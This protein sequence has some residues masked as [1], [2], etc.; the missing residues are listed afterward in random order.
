MFSTSCAVVDGIKNTLVDC[1]NKIGLDM[2]FLIGLAVEALFVIIFLIRLAFSYEVRLIRGCNA[3]IDW[4]FRRKE[5]VTEENVR[6]FNQVVKAKSPKLLFNFWTRY[7]LFR[8]GPPSKYLSSENL[9]ERPLKTSSYSA[10]IRTLSLFTVIWALCA[11][12][13]VLVIKAMSESG[14]ITGEAV[15][16]SLLLGV[17]ITLIGYIFVGIFNARKRKLLD[18]LYNT[19]SMLGRFMDNACVNLTSYIDYQILFTPRE[20]DKGQVI[21]REFQDLKARREQEAFNKAKEEDITYVQYDFSSTGVD[22]SIV[23]ERAMRE[24]EKFLKRQEKTL[25]K[26]S[27]LESELDSRRKN[28]D[29]VQKESQTKIQASKENILNLR[30]MQEETTNRIESNYYRKQQTQEAAKQE[31][32]EQ[33]F[34]QQRTKYLLEKKECEDEINALKQELEGYKLETQQAMINEYQTFF[35]KFCRSAEK[36]VATVFAEKLNSLKEENEKYRQ[37][38]TELEVK[39]NNASQEMPNEENHQDEEG[40]VEENETPE[41]EEPAENADE[42]SNEGSYDEKGNYVYANGTYYDTD[43]HFHDLD[44]SIYTQDGQ[45]LGIG[46]PISKRVEEKKT[47]T[48]DGK[49]LVNF[50]DLDSFD[51]TTDE[52]QKQNIYDTAEDIIKA[53]DKDNEIEVIN[54]GRVEKEET[55]EENE[56]DVEENFENNMEQ[57]YSNEEVE[58]DTAENVSSSEGFESDSSENVET[59]DINNQEIEQQDENVEQEEVE[60]GTA[61]EAKAFEEVA[62]EEPVKQKKKAGRPRKAVSNEPKIV[63]KPGRPKKIVKPGEENPAEKRPRGRP[64]KSSSLYE[65]NKRLSEEEKKLAEM[66]EALSSE[67]AKVTAEGKDS[68]TDE[69]QEKRDALLLNIDELQNEAQGVMSS[70]NSSEEEVREINE[71][72]ENVLVEIDNLLT[73]INDVNGDTNKDENE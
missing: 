4:L 29:N 34:E 10:S 23:L 24:S 15:V 65:L 56:T 70:D 16:L 18:N 46:E 72:L 11:T 1:A 35:D 20:I 27:Q 31:Q 41:S 12:L 66:R 37:Y 21:I 32:L 42:T 38:I 51:F 73:E 57:E 71:K 64:K 59:G 9:I 62:I 3:I 28:F 45:Y 36:V 44:G 67:I 69:L 60:N 50:D 5:G 26:I 54:S 55:G 52:A 58:G 13:F 40:Q 19:V 53:V 47:T 30:K 48:E 61:E 14:V 43:G 6:E 25:V 7:A 8:E 63:R 22:G 68:R 2:A 39:M 33:E 17:L 49:K